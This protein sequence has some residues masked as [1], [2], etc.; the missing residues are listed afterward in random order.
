MTPRRIALSVW[1]QQFEPRP[2]VDTVRQW[3]AAGTIKLWQGRERGRIYVVEEGS[4]PRVS[5][6]DLAQQFERS[7]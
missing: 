6:E 4:E 7:A 1:L 3:A 2:S 5:A